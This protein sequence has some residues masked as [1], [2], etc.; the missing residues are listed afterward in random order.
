MV[1]SRSR[2]NGAV[3]CSR[4]RL[5]TDHGLVVPRSRLQ[6]GR[7]VFAT[8]TLH[9]Q[10]G[11]VLV[12]LLQWGRRVFATETPNYGANATLEAFA[13]MGPSRVRDGDRDGNKC[14]RCG[15]TLQWGRRVFATETTTQVIGL[16]TYFGLQWGRRVFATE[17]RSMFALSVAHVCASMGPSRV[18]DGDTDAGSK[19]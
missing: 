13:S 2:F 14:L 15:A 9:A 1:R 4:R 5:P 7:R 17:T 3:A 12:S 8:E 10:S 19:G 11:N 16:P 6:W 18:R